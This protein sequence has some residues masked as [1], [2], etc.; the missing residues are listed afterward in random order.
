M[1]SGLVLIGLPRP[2]SKGA[3]SQRCPI[4][5][6]LLYLRL[7][8]A[9]V[10]FICDNIVAWSQTMN[11]GFVLQQRYRNLGFC[12]LTYVIKLFSPAL[13][14][15]AGNPAAGALSTC[16]LVKKMRFFRQISPL[17]SEKVLDIGAFYCGSGT[18]I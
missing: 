11:A 17:M 13:Q 2:H 3:W 15:A 10:E 4:F 6:V 18:H 5:V 7:H 1:G 14:N 16:G 8:D 9:T 12:S